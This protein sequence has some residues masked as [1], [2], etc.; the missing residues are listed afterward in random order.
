[1]TRTVT[2]FVPAP[3][4]FSIGETVTT[5]GAAQFCSLD[6]RYQCLLRHMVGD[7]GVVCAEDKA[8]NDQAL[9]DGDRLLSAYPI[10]P[11]KPCKGHGDNCLWNDPEPLPP[12]VFRKHKDDHA[13]NGHDEGEASGLLEILAKTRGQNAPAEAAAL[14]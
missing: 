11:A 4:K 9:I 2:L 7:W 13:T 6:Y 1:M 5:R 8:S 12:W 14:P 3:R 10:D